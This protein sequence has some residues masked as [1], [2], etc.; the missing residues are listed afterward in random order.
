MFFDFSRNDS[1]FRI[2]HPGDAASVN[3]GLSDSREL[4]ISRSDNIFYY[5][6][7]LKFISTEKGICSFQKIRFLFYR[8]DAIEVLTYYL[9]CQTCQ[10]VSLALRIGKHFNIRK[11]ESASGTQESEL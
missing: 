1:F 7:Q 4:R 3:I 8:F 6:S 9:E 2:R 5:G 11:Q 10:T